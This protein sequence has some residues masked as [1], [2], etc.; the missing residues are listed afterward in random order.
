MKSLARSYVWWPGID[1][2]IENMAKSCTGCQ[3]MLRQPQTAPV[4]V[5]EWPSTP[6]QC[7]HI[8]YA[9]PFMDQMFLVVVDAHSKWPEIFPV[10]QATAAS[11]LN[12]LRSLFA[13]TGLP[14]QLVSDNGRQFTGEE[15]RCFLRSNG[16][17]HITSAPHHPATNR[18]AE[19]F[20]QS[21]KRSM[22]ASHTEGKPLQQKIDNFLLAYR[23]TTHATTGHTPAMLF[24]GQNLR[25]RLD[26]LKPDIRKD[27]QD[28]QSSMVEATRNKT[29][30]FN[31]GQKDLARDYRDPSQ[32]WQSGTI[33][34]RTGPL[35]Y[36]INVGANLVW[37]R[38]VDQ[39]LDAESHMVPQ[40]PESTSTPQ[41]SEEFAFASQP[42]VQG[43]CETT[44]A[45]T[46]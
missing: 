34:S 3:Q 33:L 44:N 37:R 6:W 15:F 39:I 8:D 30:F 2:E 24:M 9:G 46:P 41:D 43:L 7:I 26:L 10:K 20:I 42:E 25:S 19:R 5:W 4:H 13:C 31:V 23:N 12:S 45:Q 29:R 40:Q 14:Q 38:Q 11:T 22:K 32:K 28:K 17:R 36:T 21:F 18:Q 16:I 35:T 27:V 1:C